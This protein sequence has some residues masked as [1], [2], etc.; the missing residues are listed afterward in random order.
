MRRTGS[1]NIIIRRLIRSLIKAS[2]T[3]DAPIWRAVAEELSRP[4]RRRV[5]VNV[6]RI[7]RYTEEGDTVVVPGKVL[8]AGILRHPVVIAALSFSQKALEKIETAGGKALSIQE[9]VESNPK[10]RNVKIMV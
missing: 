4:R 7:N 6:S 3:H 2:R 10:G 8:G 1:T 9:L 5:A